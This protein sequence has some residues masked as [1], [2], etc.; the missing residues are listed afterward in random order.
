MALA[1]KQMNG[2][3]SV[4]DIVFPRARS[5]YRNGVEIWDPVSNFF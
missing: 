1:T 2:D 5:K 4:T 3:H